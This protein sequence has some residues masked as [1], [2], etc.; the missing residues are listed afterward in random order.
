M[1][2]RSPSRGVV[3]YR[4]THPSGAIITEIDEV[5]L[6]LLVEEEASFLTDAAKYGLKHWTPGGMEEYVAHLQKEEVSAWRVESAIGFDGFVI[7][8]LLRA[9]EGCTTRTVCFATSSSRGSRTRPPSRTNEDRDGDPHPGARRGHRMWPPRLP[10]ALVSSDRL[11]KKAQL[12]PPKASALP[13]RTAADTTEAV[14]AFMRSLDHP[15]KAQLEAVRR[16]ILGVHPSIA[17]G[18]KWNA[19]SFRTAEY[20]A[21]FHLREKAGFSVILHLGAKARDGARPEVPD[22]A[23]LLHWLGKDRALVRFAEPGDVASRQAAFASIVAKWIEPDARTSPALLTFTGALGRDPAIDSW[24]DAQPL[25][26][27][28]IARTWFTRMRQ[29]GPD[30]RELMHDGCATACVQDAPFAYVNAFKAHVNVGFFH[31]A[32]LQDP[33]GLLQG[34]GKSMRH[35]KLRPGQALD[36]PSLEA[37]IAAA[38]RDIGTRL[39]ELR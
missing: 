33:A 36:A 22:P 17:E 39:Q 34:T 8:R 12:A 9:E 6:A 32:S 14:D 37:L 38:Y 29:C 11:I 23:G 16:I 1:S 13:R 3:C 26:L 35:V 15:H 18:I 7:A 4:F 25:E 31:G 2:P 28:A 10:V 30:V 20:F 5:D 27:G 21:T 19:P 24:L